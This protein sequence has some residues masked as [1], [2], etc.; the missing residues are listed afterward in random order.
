VQA[1]FVVYIALAINDILYGAR[2]IRSERLFDLA[3]VAVAA[4]FT[5][6]AVRRYGHVHDHLEEEVVTRTRELETRTLWLDGLVRAGQGLMAGL[7]LPSTLQR[8]T[9]EARQ[10][11]GSPH[12]KVLLVDRAAGIFRVGATSGA[13]VPESFRLELGQSYSGKVARTGRPLFVADLQRAPG[14]PL[15]ERD[16][17]LGLVSYLGLPI[18]K[19]GEVLGVLTINTEAPREY[20][21]EELAY[22]SSFADQAGTAIDNARLLGE[23]SNR[24]RRLTTLTTLTQ[25]LTSTLSADEVLD[26]VVRDAVELFGS[27]VARLW[28]LEEGGRTLGLRAEAGQRTN[29]TGVTRMA[30]GQGI[31]GRVVATQTPVVIDDI[32]NAA[33]YEAE[34]LA[35][36]EAELALAHV[37]ELQ[38]MVPICAY[39]K[40]VRNDRNYWET[41]ETYISERSRATFSH[42]ICPGCRE[43]IVRPELERWKRQPSS[44]RA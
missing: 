5:Y 15:A 18:K 13:P 31:V 38:G 32:E 17:E 12:V 35:R 30:V 3:F 24:E 8:I 39:C 34:G 20:L 28:L 27:S 25:G 23:A 21:P 42:G 10:L 4:G 43:T 19:G 22:L 26:R 44:R 6:I 1:G 37:K 9:A 33:A 11:A 41:I 40:K 2:V 7:D 16:R 14:N 36:R 29:V